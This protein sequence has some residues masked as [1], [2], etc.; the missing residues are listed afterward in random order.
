LGRT[1][2]V[3][4]ISGEDAINF[5]MTGPA[6]RGSGV[7]Y[8]VRKLEPYGVYHKVDWEVPVG[9]NGDTYDRYWIRVE[10][11]RQSARI[12]SQCLDQMPPGPIIADMPQY[13]PP[14]KPQVMRDMESLI[15]I[16]SSSP[17]GSNHRRVKPIARPKRPRVNWDFLSSATGAPVPIG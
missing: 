7:S 1:K 8:D 14:P 13:I 10:E 6:L 4:V 12:I 17:K 16:S 15:H 3:A 9:K 5:G 2:H 11:M